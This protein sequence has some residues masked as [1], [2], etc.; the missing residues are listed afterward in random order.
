MKFAPYPTLRSEIFAE[1]QGL[2]KQITIEPIM[3][4]HPQILT[5]MI[6]K[7]NPTIVNIGADSGKNHLPEPPKDK[8]LELIHKLEKFTIVNQKQNLNRLI[9]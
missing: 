7:C 3:N 5:E 6:K 4:F 9:Q 8:V 1:I 2:E